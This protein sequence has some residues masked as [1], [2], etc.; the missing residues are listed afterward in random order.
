MNK[1]NVNKFYEALKSDNAMAEE[2][3]KQGEAIAQKTAQSAAE[4][5]V[6]FAKEK[7]YEFSVEDLKAFETEAQELEKD[8]LDKINAATGFCIY[9][10]FGMG[11][12][13][14]AACKVI[15]GGFG[16]WTD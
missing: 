2:L 9:I 14:V 13:K 1:E 12:G 8:D 5:V 16:G 15:G 6:K 11:K 4:L 10:G 7:G 3:Q